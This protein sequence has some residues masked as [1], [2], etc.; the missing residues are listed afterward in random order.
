MSFL[1][2]TLLVGIAFIASANAAGCPR[3]VSQSPYITMALQWLDREACIVGVSRYDKQ[4]PDLPRTGGI[5]DPDVD[6][7]AI[8]APD[9][10]VTSINTD[11]DLIGLS[12]PSATRIVKVGGFESMAAV[13]TMMQTLAHVSASPRQ[14]VAQQF[15]ARWR[16]LARSSG[17]QGE[18]V[19]LLTACTGTPYSYGRAHMLGDLFANAGFDVV[20]PGRVQPLR[21]GADFDGIEAVVA[22]Y[23]PQIIFTFN[24][25]T[26]DQC[27]VILGERAQRIIHLNGDDFLNPGPRQFTALEALAKEMKRQ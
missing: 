25:S 9:L 14:E 4:L 2:R 11:A 22:H 5:Q 3:I 27:R 15:G 16:A 1:I 7:L 23:R 19:L 17:A 6:A 12:M 10:I 24:R 13:E 21:P 26:D 8:L 18:R 20:D